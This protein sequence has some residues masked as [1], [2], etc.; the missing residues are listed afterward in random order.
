MRSDRS[1]VGL[2]RQCIEDGEISFLEDP[3]IFQQVSVRAAKR[4]VV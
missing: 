2:L 1:D 3:D 4:V